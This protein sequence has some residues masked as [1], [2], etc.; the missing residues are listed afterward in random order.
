M[1]DDE[2]EYQPN[3]QPVL[4]QTFDNYRTEGRITGQVRVNDDPD[5]PDSELAVTVG[6][7]EFMRIDIW[8]DQWGTY[9]T[10]ELGDATKTKIGGPTI[11]QEDG[12]RS[13]L[14]AL[15]LGLTELKRLC[16]FHTKP[17]TNDLPP[18][19]PA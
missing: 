12:T 13:F 16:D 6:D 10:F 3:L 9:L 14:D 7:Q 18:D 2:I 4:I 11:A 5:Y 15:I 17:S 1:D 8:R 19:V